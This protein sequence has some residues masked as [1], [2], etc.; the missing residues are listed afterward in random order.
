MLAAAPFYILIMIGGFWS[1]ALLIMGLPIAH[2]VSSGAAVGITVVS[3]IIGIVIYFGFSLV[4]GIAI[5]AATAA[6][7]GTGGMG[8]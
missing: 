8:N 7:S 5:V 2:D 6:T 3:F 1:L 4:V